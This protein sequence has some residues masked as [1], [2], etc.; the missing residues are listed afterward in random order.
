MSP[1]ATQSGNDAEPPTL[2]AKIHLEDG[3][4]LTGRSFGC[5]KAIEGEVSFFGVFCCFFVSIFCIFLHK[6][7]I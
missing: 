7:Q 5:H 1:R 6:K 4:T 3:T 2:L